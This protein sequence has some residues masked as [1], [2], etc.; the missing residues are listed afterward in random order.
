MIG[1]EPGALT[2][3]NKESRG[4]K[5][6]PVT[7][8][9]QLRKRKKKT[10]TDQAT[11]KAVP[12]TIKRH[13][14]VIVNEDDQSEEPMRT[15]SRASK[16]DKTQVDIATKNIKKKS[17]IPTVQELDPRNLP[18]M[19]YVPEEN[20]THHY[21]SIEQLPAKVHKELARRFDEF[22]LSTQTK[23]RCYRRL[24]KDPAT[25][26]DRPSCVCD[27]LTKN[28]LEVR[29]GKPVQAQTFKEGGEFSFS[30]DDK[31]IRE[32]LPCT[33]IIEQDDGYAL[34]FVPLPNAVDD[35]VSWKDLWFWVVE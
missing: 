15:R 4:E 31:C 20:R 34:C 17:S 14:P 8:T 29:E 13:R 30:A 3:T 32:R 16:A 19:L 9:A 33:H 2:M 6:G 18:I 1:L 26:M 7:A 28:L 10:S 25:Y 12:A 24:S 5:R 21:I 11:T 27:Q 35:G 22:R 23:I